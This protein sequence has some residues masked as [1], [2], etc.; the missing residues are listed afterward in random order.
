MIGG[1]NMEFDHYHI[2]KPM[3]EDIIS[4]I[5]DIEHF[6]EART[7]PDTPNFNLR[8][9]ERKEAGTALAALTSGGGSVAPLRDR[10]Y[11]GLVRPVQPLPARGARRYSIP[12]LRF[13]CG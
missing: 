4:G 3:L 13:A 6:D 2:D 5:V 1:H 9:P 11:R 10:G 8:D 7:Y 12:R